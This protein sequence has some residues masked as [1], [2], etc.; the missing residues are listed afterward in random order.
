MSG[1]FPNAL[2]VARREYLFRVR[3]R[4]FIVTTALLGVAVLLVTMVPTILASAG[5]SYPPDVTVAVEA[6]DL[7][8]DPVVAIQALLIAAENPAA[9]LEGEAPA[10]S[11]DGGEPPAD[12]A[13][14]TRADDADAAAEA[15]RDGDLDGLLTITRGE[16]GDL[17]FEYLT[18]AGPTSRTR[19]LVKHQQGERQN[20]RELRR[21]GATM[22]EKEPPDHVKSPSPR[23]SS[24]R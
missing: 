4:A 1:L 9:L 24:A 15:V 8:S 14:V 20:H 18:D 12:R 16:D 3:G 2:H 17:T 23:N 13:R 5:V 21:R 6:D 7:A 11:D 10:P 19:L 22:V